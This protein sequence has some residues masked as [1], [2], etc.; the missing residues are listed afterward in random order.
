MTSRPSTRR[1][2]AL[3]VLV[4]L[5]AWLAPAQA[6]SP[7]ARV[8]SAASSSPSRYHYRMAGR[9]RA[10][11]LFWMG[12]D[13]VGEVTITVHRPGGDVRMV[14]LL[15]GTDP[16]KAPR[17]INRWGYI[18]EER[19]PTATAIVGL[20]KASNEDTLE[21]ATSSVDREAGAGGAVFKAIRASVTPDESR[22]A[23][24]LLSLS[25]NPTFRDLD[26]LL[27]QLEQAPAPPR[28]RV[29]RLEAQT[30][31][32]FLLSVAELVREAISRTRRPGSR[33]RASDLPTLTYVYHG[34]LYRLRVRKLST[35]QGP[36]EKW[37]EAPPRLRVEFEATRLKN[38]NKSNFTLAVATEGEYAGVPLSI[39]YRPRWWLEAEA[40][41]DPA[42]E[43]A[44]TSNRRG[45]P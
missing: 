32:G 39:V 15:I 9:V 38:G 10:L 29:L 42:P 23:V 3:L 25:E 26:L 28:E 21:E 8:T 35:E 1:G 30:R 34:E 36:L 40:T 45:R 17:R 5:S 14:E 19:G 22:S 12:K 41:L 44:L 43:R 2:C 13:D 18:R 6:Q 16:A 20:M 37:A 33:V 27:A 7:A 4:V 31:S 24:T 11:L